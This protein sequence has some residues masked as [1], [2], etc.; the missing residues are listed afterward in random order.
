M[1]L[2]QYK[3][4][5]LSHLIKELLLPSFLFHKVVDRL[6]NFVIVVAHQLDFG[7]DPLNSQPDVACHHTVLLEGVNLIVL[8][9][10]D[11]SLD[12]EGS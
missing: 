11:F 6:F 5:G 4:E 1:L 9:L 10:I 12:T 3:S 2:S 7:V 8:H